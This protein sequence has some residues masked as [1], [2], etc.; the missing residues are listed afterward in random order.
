[1]RLKI[2]CIYEPR[3]NNGLEGF[4]LG[5]FYHAYPK[6]KRFALYDGGEFMETCGPGVLTRYF[7]VIEK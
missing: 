6:G 2:Q 3:G 4:R 5:E 1:M 7:R